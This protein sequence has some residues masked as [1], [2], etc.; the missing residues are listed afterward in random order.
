MNLI[1][2]Y[3]A[4]FNRGYLS[5]PADRRRTRR[6]VLGFL[7]ILAVIILSAFLLYAWQA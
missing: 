2:L 6:T 4:E 5:T 3:L 1:A 7:V